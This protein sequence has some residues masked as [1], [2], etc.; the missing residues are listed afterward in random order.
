MLIQK[1]RDNS[2][3]MFT[4]IIIGLIAVSFVGFGALSVFNSPPGSRPV[5]TV[6]GVEI[7]EQE[8]L[9]A[10]ERLKRATLAQMGENAD[11]FALDDAK[12]R[13]QAL[14][15]LVQRQLL[16]QS[17]DESGLRIADS[18]INQSIV[19]TK[20]FQ[21]DGA[22]NMDRFE[23]LLRNVGYTPRTYK[24][25]VAQELLIQQVQSGIA[26]SDFVTSAELDRTLSL[27]GQTRDIA[28]LIVDAAKFV[29]ADL[30][31]DQAIQAYYDNNTHLYLTEETVSIQYLELKRE[32]FL[33]QIEVTEEEIQLQY[34]QEVELAQSNDERQASH[35]LISINDEQ[36]AAAAMAKMQQ[37]QAKLA[38]GAD[39]AELAREFSDDSGSAAE[40]GDL[41]YASKGAYVEPFEDALFALQQG[42]VSEVVTTEF[43]LHL[44]K[45]HA[46]KAA[47]LP[48]LESLRDKLVRDAK[49]NKAEL[50]F[51]KASEQLGNESYGADNLEQPADIL[52]LT[53]QVS[54]PFDRSQTGGGIIGN[55][56]VINAAFSADVLTEGNNSELIELNSDH[57]V[58]LR[59]QSHS[60][61]QT[62]PLAEVRDTIV[63]LLSQDAARKKARET[64]QKII[65]DL[66][67]GQSTDE[68]AQ[69]SG[70]QWTVK[71]KA[72]RRQPGIDG[73]IIEAAFKLPK[74]AD[75]KS[76]GGAELDSGD[77]AVIA[78]TNVHEPDT[79]AESEKQIFNT[80]LA[81]QAGQVAQFEFRKHLDEQG[82]VELMAR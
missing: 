65:T 69:Q 16:R 3:S 50:L 62:K 82:D 11:P 43:G 73:G 80:Y 41:G 29:S 35:I 25:E 48:T 13:E 76:L 56:R 9:Q 53:V 66:Q 21:V 78:L 42:Q 22:F 72:R 27:N 46:I 51:V 67:A 52:D 19:G 54:E 57:V 70:Y 47:E 79:V 32:N 75:A 64:G 61:A 2:Q 4:K 24:E 5:A 23:A 14:T 10:T 81:N 38:E 36:D 74:P 71:E 7:S 40:G 63:A 33:D 55:P 8:L 68:V 60:P 12:L 28:Y 6:D 37:V 49:Y 18:R 44:I 30:V 15:G 20:E 58:V 17:A 59:N 77:Y 1:I 45:L 26:A 39:F 31:T 34:E